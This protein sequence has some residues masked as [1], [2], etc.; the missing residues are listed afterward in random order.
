MIPWRTGLF[1]LF[2]LSGFAGFLNSPAIWCRRSQSR[3]RKGARVLHY[4][5]GDEG[6]SSAI[7]LNDPP[8]EV[9]LLELVDVIHKIYS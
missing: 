5:H 2:V 6:L 8:C 7:E 9:A 4:A 3:F 1:D